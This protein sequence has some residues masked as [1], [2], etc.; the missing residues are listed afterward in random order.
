MEKGLYKDGD[1]VEQNIFSF[2]ESK[3]SFISDSNKI[4]NKSV[5]KVYGK[6]SYSDKIKYLGDYAKQDRDELVAQA[7]SY[8]LSGRTHPFSAEVKNVFDEKY[9]KT[10]GAKPGQGTKKTEYLVRNHKGTTNT[11]AERITAT[12]AISSVPEKVQNAI[13]DGTIVD[14]GKIGASQYD[15]YS[16][17]LY[18]AKNAKEEDV[19][20]EI[21][22]LVE[23]KLLDP[24]KVAKVRKSI[25]GEPDFTNIMTDV[26]YDASGNPHDVFLLNSDK[27]VS[28]Y[29]GRIYT[30]SIFDAFD[31][32]GD[33][34]DDLLWEFI[35]EP[36]RL[37]IENPENLKS[38]NEELYNL[39]KEVVE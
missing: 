21:G 27:L 19:I 36:F 35:S 6:E 9:E 30:D 20:H 17:I 32:N 38:Q 4:V 18:I 11:T 23:N 2:K 29:Q 31:E 39:I 33:F 24:V 7:I 5:K 15:Y 3:Y 28:E 12:N 37:Y 10:F 1:F 34:R 14:V 26:L 22:H 8:E 25:I 16:D 13:H